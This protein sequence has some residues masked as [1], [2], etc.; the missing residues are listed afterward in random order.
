MLIVHGISEHCGRWS[1]VGRFFAEHGVDTYSFDLRG[2]GRSGG[3]KM[4]IEN[5]SQYADD[6]AFVAETDV[7]PLGLPWVLYGHSMGGLI[8]T[9]YL[10]SDRTLPNAAV[11][12]APALDADVPA[13][14]VL[15]T[16]VLNR[17][18]PGLRV[19]NS[20][21]ADHLSKDPAVGEAYLSDPLV[22]L[23]TSARLGRELL[24]RE[25]PSVRA[26]AAEVDVPTF[27]IH[28][29]DDRL[30]PP[31]ASA[32]LAASPSVERKLYPGLSHELHNEPERENVL[33]DILE[34]VRR[35]VG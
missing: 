17:L 34:F 20:I 21:N 27:V 32:P 13:P 35:T 24:L 1:H 26:R 15:A 29:A 9:G 30:V 22:D 7:I 2:H 19:K 16:R 5:F 6:V 18:A 10:L 31:R 3:R 33:A 25:Q 28:G 11:L 12:S 23:R 14:L 4:Y 8:A